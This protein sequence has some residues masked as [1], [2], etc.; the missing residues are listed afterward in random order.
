MTNVIETAFD[1]Y[2]NEKNAYFSTSENK[3]IKRIYELKKQYPEQVNIKIYPEDND[4]CLCATLP[5]TWLKLNPPR[6]MEL[7][8]EDREQR[9]ARVLVAR[10]SRA[11][12][13]GA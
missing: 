12:K 1:Y 10:E 4:G 3:W 6:K 2:G 8:D 5:K 11:K 9:R 13:R 7:S